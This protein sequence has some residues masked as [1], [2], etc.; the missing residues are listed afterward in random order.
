MLQRYLKSYIILYNE[1]KKVIDTLQS[2][3]EVIRF[4]SE[5]MVK[6]GT[7]EK[8]AERL[9]LNLVRIRDNRGLCFIV[10]VPKQ[11]ILK[12]IFCIQVQ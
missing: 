11:A 1:Y 4:M 8:H 3:P 6:V 12:N 7:P 2:Q 10:G 9:A 5:S